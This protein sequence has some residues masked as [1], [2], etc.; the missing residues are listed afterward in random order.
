MIESIAA[1]RHRLSVGEASERVTTSVGLLRRTIRQTTLSVHGQPLIEV[2]LKCSQPSILANVLAIENNNLS[3]QQQWLLRGVDL[4]KF[5]GCAKADYRDFA[6]TV[7]AGL[8]YERLAEG[9]GLTR[10]EVKKYVMRDLFAQRRRY[11]A[12][13]QKAFFKRWPSVGAYIFAVNNRTDNPKLITLL[14]TIEARLVT[15]AVAQTLA[16]RLPDDV[17]F[18]PI[19]DCVLVQVTHQSTALDAFKDV[20]ENSRFKL[21]VE[22]KG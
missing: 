13:V 7:E 15:Q 9:S 10:D 18:V 14:Q 11:D 5:S 2:D 6:A 20:F 4:P 19:H 8:L 21:R 3:P 16:D 22:A 12:P 1:G 17:G